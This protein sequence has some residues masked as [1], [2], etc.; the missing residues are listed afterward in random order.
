MNPEDPLGPLAGGPDGGDRERGG[1]G[2]EDGRRL[3]RVLEALEGGLLDV[4]ILHDGLDDE[5]GGG[6]FDEVAR[7]R[8]QVADPTQHGGPRG[9]VEPP[10]F[11]FPG[12][13]FFVSDSG[14]VDRAGERVR[15]HDGVS[16]G[17]RDLGDPASHGPGAEDGDSSGAIEGHGA[18]LPVKRGFR[19]SLNAATPS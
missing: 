9:R 6:E 10:L 11:D 15:Q 2:G 3:K 1:V 13:R 8:R 19:F 7:A 4:E 14:P 17:G 5:A 16:G 12:D 18:Y